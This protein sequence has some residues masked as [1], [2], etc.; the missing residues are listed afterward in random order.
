MKQPTIET[1]RLLIRELLA[2][3]VDGMFALDSN[4][5][6]H[7]YL[8]NNPLTAK[9]QSADVIKKVQQQYKELGIGRWAMVEKSSGSLMGWT[10]FKLNTEPVNGYENFLDLG[11]RLREEYW[12]K[13]YATESSEACL[14]YIFEHWNHD[15]V[16]GMAEIANTASNRIL[17]QKLGMRFVN[18]FMYDI[19]HCH[20]YEITKA[21]WLSKRNS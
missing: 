1:S 6:V 21:E 3:D 19:A 10:G 12:G 8:G 9:E 7:L 13:G 2:T 14:D 17:H 20:F 11:Y 16:Y 18:S 5:N 15:T 4:P